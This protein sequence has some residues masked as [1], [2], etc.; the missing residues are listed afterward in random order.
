[1]ADDWGVTLETLVGSLS[2]FELCLRVVRRRMNMGGTYNRE[3]IA[4]I[5]KEREDAERRAG[6][7]ELRRK[8][9]ASL[10]IPDPFKCR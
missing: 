1:M 4:R 5:E 2:H 3:T 8:H 6:I 7:E 9:Y 10:G